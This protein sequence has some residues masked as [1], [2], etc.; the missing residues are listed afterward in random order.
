MKSDPKSPVSLENLLQLKRTERPRPEF[1]ADFDREL[2]AKQ[3]VAIMEKR[4]WWWGL[5]RI[6]A[7][8]V[9]H[10]APLG[11]AA[12]LGFTFLGFHE[13]HSLSAQ[14][15]NEIVAAPSSAAVTLSPFA[16]EAPVA[17]AAAPVPANDP[18]VVAAAVTSPASAGESARPPGS[19]GIDGQIMVPAAISFGLTAPAHAMLANFAL[20]A[21]SESPV[22]GGFLSLG[23]GFSA[24]NHLQAMRSV[25]VDPLTRMAAPSSE[26]RARILMMDGLP[27]SAAAGDLA[28]PPSDRLV[29]RLSDERLYQSISRYGGG[30]D[31]FSVKF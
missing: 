30:G 15:P 16:S 13:F 2:R 28:A 31:H 14:R 19:A 29:S 9:R 3:L 25:V 17:L 21:G 24:G 20:P 4:A 26:H 22:A 8:V 1:W 11:A 12:A 6:F 27:N 5:P 10:P 7:S 18:A 23:A